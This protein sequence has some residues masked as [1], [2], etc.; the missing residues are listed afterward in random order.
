MKAT[1]ASEVGFLQEHTRVTASQLTSEVEQFMHQL[2]LREGQLT[3]LDAQN[4]HLAGEL[5]RVRSAER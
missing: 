3:E 2:Q 1:H 5:E 4:R